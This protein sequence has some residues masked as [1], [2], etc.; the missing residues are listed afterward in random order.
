MK[1]IAALAA[2]VD[3]SLSPRSLCSAGAAQ[4]NPSDGIT[5]Y[6]D[7]NSAAGFVYLPVK[8]FKVGCP[9]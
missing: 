8:K 7:L 6:P 5:F 3:S 4:T 2:L 1:S 9:N